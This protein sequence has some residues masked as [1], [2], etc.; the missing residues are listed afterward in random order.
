MSKRSKKPSGP[1]FTR[2][3]GM[4]YDPNPGPRD[5]EPREAIVQ[6]FEVRTMGTELQADDVAD[7]FLAIQKRFAIKNFLSQMDCERE[8]LENC[9]SFP[10]LDPI[11]RAVEQ[12][13]KKLDL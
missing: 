12:A 11:W 4:V 10:E 6:T 5:H 13:R 7:S 8:K 2:A 3:P 9:G 1:E